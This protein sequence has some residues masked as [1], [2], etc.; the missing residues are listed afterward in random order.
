MNIPYSNRRQ[1]MLSVVLPL[2]VVL[3]LLIAF[4]PSVQAND[5]I[6]DLV[7]SVIYR[8]EGESQVSQQTLTTC[9]YKI[10]RRSIKCVSTPRNKTLQ[11]VVK[12]YG[13]KLRDSKGFTL[14]VAPVSD[15]GI[16]ILQYDYQEPGKDT[17]QWLYLPEIGSVKRVASSD[18]APKSGSLFGSE[19]SLEDL[20]KPKLERFQ[21]QL[22]EKSPTKKAS[23]ADSIVIVAQTPNAEFARRTN[24]SKRKYWIDTDRLLILKTQY[25]GWNG[26]LEKVSYN[27]DVEKIAGIWTARKMVMRNA[28]T[29]RISILTLDQI[30]YNLPVSDAMLEIRMLKDAVFQSS[31]LKSLNEAVGS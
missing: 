17:D 12:K 11:S 9:A 16:S 24:Y 8:Y 31:M 29:K 25:Y 7:E 22:I 4:A 19:F 18:D 21:W 15:N 6:V 14:I 5:K 26:E 23:A 28:Q 1:R 3:P 20:E 13:E 30:K 27:S 2:V 10:A